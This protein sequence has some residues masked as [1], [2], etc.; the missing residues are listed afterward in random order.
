MEQVRVDVGATKQEYGVFTRFCKHTIDSIHIDFLNR[1][2]ANTIGVDNVKA[3]M[4]S[5][6]PYLTQLFNNFRQIEQEYPSSVSEYKVEPKLRPTTDSCFSSCYNTNFGDGTF[7]GWYGYYGVNSSPDNNIGPFNITGVTGG[8][9]GPQVKAAG[10]D[11]NTGNDYQLRITA[12][13]ATDWFL[14]NYSTY[15]M[16]QVSP[17]ATAPYSVMMGDSNRNG[18][19]T[20]ILSQ[21]FYV[22]P[23]TSSLTYQYSVFL[24]NPS[25][26][27]YYAQPFFSVVVLDQNG[28]TIPICG[29]Y[30]VSADSG[31]KFHFKGIWYPVESDSVYWKPW[32]IVNVPLKAYVGQCITILFQV[33]DCSL[34][35]HFGYA[36]VT[37]SCSPLQL[38]TSSPNFCGQDSV[39][40]TAPPGATYYAWI[41]G[42][43]DTI[44]SDT[45]Q[46]TVWVKDSGTYTVIT[47]P[48]TG[49]TCADTISIHVGKIPGPPPHPKFKAD[50]VCAGQRTMFVNT[51]DSAY[52][53][54]WDFYNIGNYNISDTNKDTVYWTF[55]NPGIYV[56]KLNEILKNGCGASVYDT[57]IV[58]T[59][60]TNPSFTASP[61]CFGD[62]TFFTPSAAGAT[63]YDWNFGDPASG[64]KDSSKL[65]APGHVFTAPGNYT[66]TLT[67]NNRGGCGAVASQVITIYA[68]PTPVIR[69]K[70][71]ICPGTPDTL[72]ASGGTTYI[73]N[74]TY[75]TSSLP[76]A[77]TVTK[78][79]TLAA[80]NGTCFK[81]T[82][83][84]IVV[85]P[86]P[87]AT[88]LASKDSVCKG[89]TITLFGHGGT[90][91]LWTKGS[92]TSVIS[93]DSTVH[94]ITI[95]SDTT[96]KLYE[97]GGTCKDSVSVTIK[98]IKAVTA[99]YNQ[100]FDSICPGDNDV[101]TVTGAGGVVTGYKWSTG[102]TT[103]TITVNPTANTTYTATVYGKCDSVKQLITVK[104][105]PLPAPVITGPQWECKGEPATLTVSSSSNPTTY[106][107]SNGSTKTTITT[108]GITANTTYTVYATNTLG[109]KD[110]STYTVDLRTAPGIDITPPALAC[111][112][113]DVVLTATGSG[114]GPFTY[115]WEPGGATTDTITVNPSTKTTYTV[116]VSNGCNSTKTTVV[117]PDNPALSA[118]CNKT[119]L[120]GEDTT[121]VAGGPKMRSY[122]WAP[123]TGLICLTPSCDTVQVTPT[124]TTTYTV[125]GTDSLGCQV[126][127]LVTITI[128]IPCFSLNIP[129]VFTPDNKG[130]LGLDNVFYIKT[131]NITGWSLV[132]F[133]RWGKEM[134]NSTNPNEFWDGTTKGGAN[135]ADGVYYYIVTGTCQSV[136]YKKEGFVQLIR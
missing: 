93:T 4:Q 76:A 73:W 130:S 70:D 26:H 127:R 39:S 49:A 21:S 134:Y 6:K 50:T 65:I 82:T 48:V 103:S 63:T 15:S 19:G 36:Y 124:V 37:A 22:T 129:N 135:A 87:N 5:K 123:D 125:T 10:P 69:G 44:L 121:I 91:Y 132:I 34:G 72:F 52:G 54:S 71:T 25:G 28:D 78:T 114:Q 31:E 133:D 53:F 30:A 109:C 3:F 9:I 118:C 47:T 136:T 84:T 58:D 94:N 16:S 128:E 81:D 104:I 92:T 74:N 77:P 7:D 113:N 119:I 8:Y 101:L 89:D 33:Q 108:T 100:Q 107:W 98:L 29:Q 55:L 23:T 116:T 75:T 115:T 111:A 80:Y 79:Y 59:N 90:N 66:V 95:V 96:F 120:I 112:G 122:S 13:S 67:A 35:G 86:A 97:H 62:T 12:G 99:T 60:V 61:T 20:A 64:T 27:A 56:T 126:E 131:E 117:T 18:Q 68:V 102:A 85:V 46:Q 43:G 42:V 41:H 38:I 11:P 110:S 2:D 32:T 83:F 24:E 57:I 14:S 1:I 17:W 106:L 40:L 88:A 51:S 45:N 105:D